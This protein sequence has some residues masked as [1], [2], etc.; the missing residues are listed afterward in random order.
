M[1]FDKLPAE[2]KLMIFEI[3]KKNHFQE[4][5]KTLE[6]KLKFPQV[7]KSCDIYEARLKTYIGGFHFIIYNNSLVTHFVIDPMVFETRKKK[8]RTYMTTQYNS[9]LIDIRSHNIPDNAWIC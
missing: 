7:K 9:G 5:V 2:I 3:K 8:K 4:K 1:N 6:K